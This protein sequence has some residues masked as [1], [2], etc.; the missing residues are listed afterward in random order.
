M[1]D[2]S[3]MPYRP[4]GRLSPDD[5]ASYDETSIKPVATAAVKLA[6][7]RAL[8]ARIADA[9]LSTYQ[10]AVLECVMDAALA[11]RATVW[12]PYQTLVTAMPVADKIGRSSTSTTLKAL[13]KM[14]FIEHQPGRT[15]GKSQTATTLRLRVPAGWDLWLEDT[16][17]ASP[18]IQD[19]DSFDF[20]DAVRSE[21]QNSRGS[22]SQH[23]W[24]SG[25][26]NPLSTSQADVPS[27]GLND[28][29]SPVIKVDEPWPIP[30]DHSLNSARDLFARP[31]PRSL[32][33][34]PLHTRIDPPDDQPIEVGGSDN[35][36]LP[37]TVAQ[38]VQLLDKGINPSRFV[39][40]MRQVV[41]D[42]SW[43]RLDWQKLVELQ[44]NTAEIGLR[45]KERDILTSRLVELQAS[46]GTAMWADDVAESYS[47]SFSG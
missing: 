15:N 40:K 16:S 46:E 13:A 3:T 2:A 39:F 45:G 17:V 5:R 10:F 35:Y 9:R 36:R 28:E 4:K 7:L 1:T 23:R 29:T 22:E 19:A 11:P 38:A 27:E 41:I 14:G 21:S 42:K 30:D 20:Q 12:D 25:S 34:D 6:I 26:Q 8:L 31:M 44:K 32:P 43:H 24:R 18:E 33:V 47:A 37:L